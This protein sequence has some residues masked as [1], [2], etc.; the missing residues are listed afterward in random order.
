MT[1]AHASGAGAHAFTTQAGVTG[2]DFQNNLVTDWD[3]G[4]YITEGTTGVI[5]NNHFSDM[6]GNS[7]VTKSV[8]MLINGNDFANGA[9]T[10]VVV[11]S[12]SST[13]DLTTFI[14]AN[15]T[16]D[17]PAFA[18]TPISVY[19][20]APG[21]ETIIGT[22]EAELVR[23]GNYFPNY[24]GTS[25]GPF[26]VD[27]RGG[28]DGIFTSDGND[29]IT[30]GAGNDFIV[31]GLG[32]D[33]ARYTG[34]R[35]DYV[36]IQ[37]PD[38]AV[39]VSD[40]RPGG[41]DGFDTLYGVETFVFSDGTYSLAAVLDHAPTAAPDLFAATEN[42]TL[43]TGNVLTNDYDPDAPGGDTLVV[44]AVNGADANVG[45]VITGVYGSL[46]LNADG[47][48]TY[49]ANTA[50]A[51]ALAENAH[52]IDTFSYTTTDSHGKT[53]TTSVVFNVTG[54]NDDPVVDAVHSVNGSTFS[55]IAGVTGSGQMRTQT[56]SVFFTDVNST[57]L[58]TLKSAGAVSVAWKDTGNNDVSG[59]LTAGQIALLSGL[60][61]SLVGTGNSV[62]VDWSYSVVESSLDFLGLGETLT[63]SRIVTCPG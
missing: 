9:Y 41:P 22:N 13:V 36:F 29:D 1:A 54:T 56:G 15:N 4:A 44:S 3:E 30:G 8:V 21:A 27:G 49:L 51:E 53:S 48:F 5:A 63:V 57:D 2:L 20:N 12:G 61:P 58:L 33:T 24:T 34:Q 39:Y 10:H 37:A 11:A 6:H 50:L 16:F 19:P 60:T 38:G 32:T 52:G 18:P 46:T 25:P 14:D 43:S 35:S 42:V 28:D 31:A 59:Q 7:I 26:T 23:G 47:T 55:E 62:H 40:T 17:D 45:A